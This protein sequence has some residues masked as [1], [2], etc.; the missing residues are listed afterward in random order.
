MSPSRDAVYD[1]GSA[2]KIDSRFSMSDKIF[3]GMQRKSGY[4]VARIEMK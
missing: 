4:V 1:I 2:E 3:P